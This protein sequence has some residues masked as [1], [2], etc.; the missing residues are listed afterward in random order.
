MLISLSDI[1]FLI[2]FSLCCYRQTF[3][4]KTKVVLQNQ[5][6]ERARE[7]TDYEFNGMETY[8]YAFIPLCT[9][10]ITVYLEKKKIFLTCEFSFVKTSRP[11]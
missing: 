6:G 5:F 2:P 10:I 8:I 1:Y 9:I 4:I 11:F 3:N 7:N